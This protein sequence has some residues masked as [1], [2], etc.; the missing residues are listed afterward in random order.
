MRDA[1][2]LLAEF[3]ALES[4]EARQAWFH[5][6]LLE[7]QKAVTPCIMGDGLKALEQLAAAWDEFIEALIEE[8]KP[9]LERLAEIATEYGLIDE[10]ENS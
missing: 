1:E 7:E 6:L 5:A 8:L 2:T 10:E 9:A 3:D 4:K